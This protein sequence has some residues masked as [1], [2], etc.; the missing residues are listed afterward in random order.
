M[1]ILYGFHISYIR[2]YKKSC[3]ESV[4]RSLNY[5]KINSSQS[6]KFLEDFSNLLFK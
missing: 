3:I 5:E 1:L 2:K 6:K 4:K